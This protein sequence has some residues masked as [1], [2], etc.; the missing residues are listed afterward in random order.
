M[1][2]GNSGPLLKPE[3][4][5]SG[6][7]RPQT[8][9]SKAREIRKANAPKASI[10]IKADAESSCSTVLLELQQ[11]CLHVFRD[12]LHPS[13]E[14]AVLL[15]EVKGHLYNRDFATAFGKEEY[16]RVYASRWSPSR[17]L[18]YVQ[19]FDDIEEFVLP[20]EGHDSVGSPDKQP[21]EIAC[22][23]GGAGAELVALGGWLS[24]VRER[25]ADLK[26]S[27]KL[28][29]IA[30]WGPTMAALQRRVEMTPEPAKYA[31]TVAK[32]ESQPLLPE[33]ALDMQFQ[34]QDV[35]EWSE[36]ELA[37]LVGKAKLVTLMFTLNELYSTDRPKTQRLLS[38][39]GAAMP[40]D[41][42]L[43]VVDS[44]GSYSTVSINE[45]EKKYP[46]QWL[47][48][49]TLLGPPQK[50]DAEPSEKSAT[51]EK[52][53]SEDSKWFRLQGL[54]Y[55][56]ELENMRYQIHLYKRLG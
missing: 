35:L 41:A 50:P 11:R 34:K 27:V 3:S 20:D 21:V 45:A 31:S 38:F 23:G 7:K 32:E 37:A 15:Q 5:T 25:E 2:K 16:L 54:Q 28:V 26:L 9:K 22:L 18:G 29:D 42:L 53:M 52:V 33:G 13:G 51:W 47:L 4:E 56:I 40:S 12:A 46:M 14:D 24:Q 39:L 49:Y 43:L 10:P 30:S 6:S 48:D 19:I 17:A 55:P 36:A 8:K 44:P 1:A